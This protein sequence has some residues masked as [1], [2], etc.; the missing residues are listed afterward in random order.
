M[1]DRSYDNENEKEKDVFLSDISFLAKFSSQRLFDCSLA[2]FLKKY[3]MHSDT[4]IV[5][6]VAYFED[7]WLLDRNIGWHSGLMPGIVTSNNGLEVTNR[8]FKNHFHGMCG[9]SIES[10]EFFIHKLIL[11]SSFI[12]PFLF[13]YKTLRSIGNGYTVS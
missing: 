1:K 9:Q 3:K 5:K 6:N 11:I 12:P 4:S 10:I 2:L 13:L 8:I 7:Y